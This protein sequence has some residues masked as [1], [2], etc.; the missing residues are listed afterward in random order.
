ML[1]WSSNYSPFCLPQLTMSP[2]GRNY[3]KKFK[4]PLCYPP[5]VS[6]EITKGKYTR[7]N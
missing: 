5:H 1:E 6:G 3:V 4:Y 7:E 2:L